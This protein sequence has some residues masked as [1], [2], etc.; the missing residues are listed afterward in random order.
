VIDSFI[1]KGIKSCIHLRR[2][3]Q[4]LKYEDFAKLD[5]QNYYICVG[6]STST[7]DKVNSQY[8]SECNPHFSSR[9]CG[10]ELG[11]KPT[12]NMVS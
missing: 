1:I 5:L 2:R 4:S 9:F 3:A 7:K 11:L 10:T 12:S 6:S 8:V